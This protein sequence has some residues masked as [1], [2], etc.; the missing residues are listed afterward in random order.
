MKPFIY[1]GK[2]FMAAKERLPIEIKRKVDSFFS[3]ISRKFKKQ[4][5]RF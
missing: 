1:V 5:Y 3:K 2:E 4:G